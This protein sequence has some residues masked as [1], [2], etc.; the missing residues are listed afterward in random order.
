MCAPI[1][2]SVRG[3]DLASSEL[4]PNYSIELFVTGQE[5]ALRVMSGSPSESLSLSLSLNLNLSLSLGLR[6]ETSDLRPQTSDL[7]SET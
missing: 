6:P 4:L 3:R 1:K 7:K 5:G 2:R